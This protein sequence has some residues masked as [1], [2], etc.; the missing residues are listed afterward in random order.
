MT[1]SRRQFGSRARSA[2]SLRWRLRQWIHDYQWPIIIALLLGSLMLGYVGFDKYTDASGL[3]AS[4]LDLLYLTLQLAM[5]ESGAVTGDV[6]WELEVA[7]WLVPTLTAYTAVLAA[8]VVFR[9]QIQLA[10]LWFIRDHVIIGG[11]GH[12]GTLL[13][14]RLAER[15]FRMVVIER[16][17]NNP[18][19]ADCMDQGAIVLEGDATDPAMLHKAVVK[20]ARYLIGVC[21]QDG[22][23]AEIAVNAQH[24]VEGRKRYPLT[25]IIHLVDL[26]LCDLLREREIGMETAADFRLEIF[27]IYDRGARVLL[28]EHPPIAEDSDGSESPHVLVVG[29]GE[30]GE[31]LIVHMA[32]EWYERHGE[33]ARQLRI[34]VIDQ[35]AKAKVQLLHSRYTKMSHCCQL[36]PFPIDSESSEFYNAAYLFDSGSAAT[37]HRIYV[38]LDEPT[39]G[40]QAA[41]ALRNQIDSHQPPIVV[42][43][44]E[45]VGLATLLQGPGS[46]PNIR[47]FGLLERTCTPDLVL[48]GTHE[49]IAQGLHAAYLR[50]RQESGVAMGSERA[51]VPWELLPPDLQESNRQQVDHIGMR[52]RAAGYGIKPL[53]DWNASSFSF[54]RQEVEIMA[55][56]EHER[57]RKER[58]DQGWRFDPLL[59]DPKV[60]THPDLVPWKELDDSAREKNRQAI[61]VLPVLLAR[62]GFQ[63]YRLSLRMNKALTW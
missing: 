20:R 23:N 7:R 15:G 38:C 21:G 9:K 55:Q 33:E 14:Q 5:L 37:F 28:S 63:V 8:A 59:K 49:L 61:S 58:L 44:P 3:Q 51:L 57:W 4:R 30:L 36:I 47:P 6:S 24:L 29:L 52:L 48:G 40:L 39:V 53:T 18:H 26:Q 50:E 41:L 19:L 10:R 62:A 12:K 54:E 27:N 1:T 25:C 43:M 56:H 11:L 32:R 16:D 35:A 22:D 13:A 46:Y 2:L 17:Q 42:Q 31:S 45:D 60:K 34:S